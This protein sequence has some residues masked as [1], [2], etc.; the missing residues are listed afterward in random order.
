MKATDVIDRAC[1]GIIGIDED[2]AVSGG[3]DQTFETAGAMDERPEWI[4][5]DDWDFMP[6]EEKIALADRMIGL[7]QR[8]KDAAQKAQR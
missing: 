8:Y 6:K 1:C 2:L 3:Y 7:W 5:E 4:D